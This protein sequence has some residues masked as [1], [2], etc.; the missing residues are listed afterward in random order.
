MSTC[1]FLFRCRREFLSVSVTRTAGPAGPL[2]FSGVT[3]F[4]FMMLPWETPLGNKLTHQGLS[5][6]MCLY[7]PHS[8]LFSACF[9]DT[10]SKHPNALTWNK[11]WFWHDL[12]RLGLKTHI[13]FWVTIIFAVT[14]QGAYW[15]T[16]LFLLAAGRNPAGVCDG[17]SWSISFT[18]TTT[19]YLCGPTKYKYA[20]KRTL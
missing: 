20:L 14:W 13:I 17:W 12:V 11:D 1:F 5:F 15:I 19:A 9:S 8:L 4:G 18:C 2:V 3:Q 6:S 16:E 10:N 7:F